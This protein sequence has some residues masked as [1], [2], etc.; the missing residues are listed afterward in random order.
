M[1]IEYK[2][3]LTGMFVIGDHNFDQVIGDVS[4]NGD[5]KRF[6]LRPRDFKQTPYGSHRSAPAI[7]EGLLLSDDELI[8]RIK[9]K[10]ERKSWIRDICRAQNVP[11]LDQNGTNFCWNFGVCGATMA[12]RA[13]SGYPLVL[14]SPASAACQIKNFRN[15]GGWGMEAVEFA[16][17]NGWCRQELWP[18]ASIDRRY[19]TP[20]AKQDALTNRINNFWDVRANLKF[21]L[22]L[23]VRDIPVAVA[24]NWW[25]HLVFA[26]F[27]AYL[28]GGAFGLGI[29]NSWSEDWGD[30]GTGLLTGS[31]AMPDDAQAIMG[32]TPK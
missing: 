17:D 26:S 32:S 27:G 24:F 29:T 5:M 3:D 2:S 31:R 16:V 13:I 11:I 28:G 25:S 19:L 7:D 15:E 1:P 14:L 21:V 9:E 22:S 23:V 10:D 6:G 12:Y 18:Q 20:E 30:R 8:A 4:V